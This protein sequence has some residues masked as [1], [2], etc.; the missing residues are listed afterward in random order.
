L[1]ELEDQKDIAA[2]RQQRTQSA[3]EAQSAADN[4]AK[5][6]AAL[7]EF[8]E[9]LQA[10]SQA[11]STIAH[12]IRHD[13][14][15]CPICATEFP[16]G[17]LAAL[18]RSRGDD[19]STSASDL[20]SSL[21]TAQLRVEQLNG[22]AASLDREIAEHDQ[23]LATLGALRARAASANQQLVEAG[24]NAEALYDGSEVATLEFELGVLDAA[25]LNSPNPGQIKTQSDE[26]E[27]QL[28]AEQAKQVSIERA[29]T[30]A[31]ET[32]E[33]ARSTLLQYPD[34]WTQAGGLLVDIATETIASAR[35]STDAGL[36]L[37]NAQAALRECRVELDRLREAEATDTAGRESI[38]RRLNALVIQ[39]QALTAKWTAGDQSG[40]PDAS[41]ITQQRARITERSSRIAVVREAQERLT[42]GYRKWLSDN[43][44][45]DLESRI[46]ASLHAEGCG[47]E[48][49]V[50][51]R[52]ARNVDSAQ[53]ALTT[54]QRARDRMSTVGEQMT[55]RAE[56]FAGEVLEP[57]NA[58]I[59]RFA[60]T[61]MTWTDESI[62]Y[63]AEHHATSSSLRPGIVRVAPD[64]STTQLEMNPNLY[65]SEGQLSALSVA[66]LLAA[67]TTFGWSRWRGLLMD[68][69]LQHND[70]IHASAFMDL[71]RQM[72]RKLGYQ[73]ILSTHDSAEAQFLVRKCSS[74]GIP[75]HV[76]ELAHRGD[77]GLISV[78]AA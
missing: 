15:H 46:D 58:T 27:A 74:A 29:R 11:I 57:L 3:I 5:L 47:S 44:L 45:R 24:G 54:A 65:F 10:L 71:L 55:E 13:D 6:S 39:R 18:A 69:P 67:S 52:L 51:E 30:R 23:L 37:A 68:D 17:Q 7:R 38:D 36:R 50:A 72:V 31:S 73:V 12:R 28:R 41:R 33:I 32:I 60:R 25:L 34:F 1:S 70:V 63:R 59:K 43:H 14:T 35:R 22:R 42:A 48:T 26:A 66:A 53:D 9:R 2:L 19:D 76:H 62:T 49:D 77:D 78:A 8:D 4:I 16:P 75:Y 64:G 61:L 40:E 56:S 21:A 20:A